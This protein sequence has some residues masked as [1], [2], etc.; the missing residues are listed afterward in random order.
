MSSPPPSSLSP[1]HEPPRVL[2][3]QECSHDTHCMSHRGDLY[4]ALITGGSRLVLLKNGVVLAQSCPL[5]DEAPTAAGAEMATSTAPTTAEAAATTASRGAT[6]CT[7]GEPA[8][9]LSAS[10][11]RVCAVSVHHFTDDVLRVAVATTAD[12]FLFEFDG[13]GQLWRDTRASSFWRTAE[14]TDAVHASWIPPPSSAAAS[15]GKAG[16]SAS[17]CTSMQGRS[18]VFQTSNASSSSAAAWGSGPITSGGQPTQRQ[19]GFTGGLRWRRVAFRLDGTLLATRPGLTEDGNTSLSSTTPNRGTT[20][21]PA[22]VRLR[23]ASAAAPATAVPVRISTPA[24]PSVVR[25]VDFVSVDTLCIVLDTEAVLVV[26]GNSNDAP[27]LTSVV[28][29][30]AAAVEL[31]D[32]VVWRSMGAYRSLAVCRVNHHVALAL[33]HATMVVFPSCVFPADSQVPMSSPASPGLVGERCFSSVASTTTP[34]L[35]STN[36]ASGGAHVTATVESR[37][38]AVAPTPAFLPTSHPTLVRGF[39][40]TPGQ[41]TGTPGASASPAAGGYTTLAERALTT[42]VGIY[43]ITDMQWHCVSSHTLLCVTCTRPQ[44]ETG[45]MMLYTVQSLSNVRR[46]TNVMRENAD[47]GWGPCRGGYEDEELD[48]ADAGLGLCGRSVKNIVQLVPAGVIVLA[49]TPSL[50]MPGLHAHPCAS[51]SPAFLVGNATSPASTAATPLHTSSLQL[52]TPDVA[53]LS[54]STVAGTTWGGAPPPPIAEM[55]TSLVPNFSHF[56]EANSLSSRMEFVHV[57][58]DGTV[59]TSSYAFGRQKHASFAKQRAVGLACRELLQPLLLLYSS[60]VKVTVLPTWRTRPIELGHDTSKQPCAVELMLGGARRYRM[61]LRFTSGVVLA[62]MVDLSAAVYRVECFLALGCAP[63]LSLR[64]V[65]PLAEAEKVHRQPAPSFVWSPAG[66]STILIAGLLGFPTPALPIPSETPLSLPKAPESFL[67]G[68][69]EGAEDSEAAQ[70]AGGSTSAD[71]PVVTRTVSATSSRNATHAASDSAE[72]VMPPRTVWAVVLLQV[73]PSGMQARVLTVAP[74]TEVHIPGVSLTGAHDG[75]GSGSD[76][77]DARQQASA[78]AAA[79]AASTSAR[80]VPPMPLTTASTAAAAGCAAQVTEDD[81]VSFMTLRC[82]EKLRFM[83]ALLKAAQQDAGRLLAQLIAKYGA[84]EESGEAVGVTQASEKGARMDDGEVEAVP[85]MSRP[86]PVLRSLSVLTSGCIGPGGEVLLLVRANAL[87]GG[88]REGGEGGGAAGLIR[89]RPPCLEALA[90]VHHL[91][92]AGGC[93]IPFEPIVAEYVPVLAEVQQRWWSKPLRPAQLSSTCGDTSPRRLEGWVQDVREALCACQRVSAAAEGAAVVQCQVVPGSP[94]TTYVRVRTPLSPDTGEVGAPTSLQRLLLPSTIDPRSITCVTGALLVNNDVVIGVL[95]RTSEV[96]SGA[97]SV[98][99]LYGCPATQSLAAS[100]KATAAATA[101]PSDNTGVAAACLASGSSEFGLEATLPGVDAFYLSASGEAVVLRRWPVQVGMGP[102]PPTESAAVHGSRFERWLRC[103]PKGSDSGYSYVQDCA[104][105]PPCG[106]TGGLPGIGGRGS[107][108]AP[109]TVTALMTLDVTGAWGASPVGLSVADAAKLGS[110]RTSTCHIL[111]ATTSN[112][113]IH[114][115]QLPLRSSGATASASGSSSASV[116]GEAALP[117]YHPDAVMQLIGMGR[118]NALGKVLTCVAD[119]VREVVAPVE[120]DG[121]ASTVDESSSMMLFDQSPEELARRL[122]SSAVARD[123]HDRPKVTQYEEVLRRVTPPQ[124]SV[125]ALLAEEMQANATAPGPSSLAPSTT[126]GVRFYDF[127]ATCGALVS[128]LTQLLPQVTLGRLDN[129]EHLKLLCILEALRDTL[130][131]SRSV[132]EAAARYLFYSR[133]VG[134]GRRL[135]L[136]SADTPAAAATDSCAPINSVLHFE[137]ARTATRIV[138]T[139]SY[140]WAAMS[141]SQS[142]LLSLLFDRASTVYVDGGAGGGAAVGGGGTGEALAPVTGGASAQDLT[143][144]QVK[145]SGVAFWL[146]SAAD[147]RT[148][149]DRVA[150]HQ[151]QSTKELTDCALM[152]CTARKVGTLAALAKAQNNQRLHAFFSRDFSKDEHNRA[153]AAANAYAAISKNMPQYGAAFFLLAGDVRSAVQVLLQRC[154]NPSLALFVLRAAGD[155]LEE[156]PSGA[157]T[158]LEWYIAQR[159]AEAEVCGALDM[160]ELACLSWID[161]NPPRVSP[162]VA[163]QRRIRALQRIAAHPTAHPEALCA[164]RYARDCVA[165]LAYRGDQF[166]SPAREVVFL[167]RLG[168]YCL[169]HR[170]G[171]NGYLHYHDAEALLRGL[172]AETAA[173]ARSGTLQRTSNGGG[174]S[175]RAPPQTAKMAADFNTGTLLFRGFGGSDD[176]D[177]GGSDDGGAPAHA[178]Q[179]SSSSAVGVSAADASSPLFTLSDAAAAAVEAEVQYVYARTGATGRPG[180][181]AA[182]SASVT[183]DAGECKDILRRMLLSFTTASSFMPMSNMAAADGGGG[184]AESGLMPSLATSSSSARANPHALFQQLLTSLLHL[185]SAGEANAQPEVPSLSITPRKP[186]DGGWC[187]LC[188]PLLHFLLSN[189]ALE[190]ANY[191][192]LLA[193]QRIPVSTEGVLKA[194]VQAKLLSDDGDEVQGAS[195]TPPPDADA[196]TTAPPLTASPSPLH[197]PLT[198]FFHLLV[199]HMRRH[200]RDAWAADG[201]R[202]GGGQASTSPGRQLEP[203]GGKGWVWGVGNDDDAEAVAE[204]DDTMRGSSE[205]DDQVHRSMFDALLAAGVAEEESSDRGARV[206][207]PSC[208]AGA[209]WRSFSPRA[210]ADGATIDGDAPGDSMP[211]RLTDSAQVSLLLSCCQAQLH[212]RLMAHLK[213]LTQAELD[214]EVITPTTQRAMDAGI[215]YADALSPEAQAAVVQRRLLQCTLL[216]DV[217]SRWSTL[218]EECMMRIYAAQPQ[219]APGPLT[220]PNGVFLEVQQMVSLMRAVLV[221]VLDA[222]PRYMQASASQGTAEASAAAECGCAKKEA[223]DGASDPVTPPPPGKSTTSWL[224]DNTL[225]LLELCATQLEL[226]WTLPAPAL[227]QCSQLAAP[228]RAAVELLQESTASHTSARAL[229]EGMLRPVKVA[230]DPLADHNRLSNAGTRFNDAASASQ[231]LFAFSGSATP[232]SSSHRTRTASPSAPDVTPSPDE[233]QQCNGHTDVYCPAL[234]YMQLAWMRRHH[235]HALLRGLLLMVTLNRGQGQGQRP[236]STDRL[237]LAQ[238]NHSATGVHFD[239]SSCD[240]VVW[241]TES[242]TSVG[243]GFRELLAGDNEEALWKQATERNL[244]TA[245]F[246]LG[247]TAQHERLRLAMEHAEQQYTPAVIAAVAA[248]SALESRPRLG[249][250]ANAMP[251]S[252]PHLPFFVSRHL[253]GHL[254]L[255]PFASQE[256]VASFRCA[257]RHGQSAMGSCSGTNGGVGTSSSNAYGWRAWGV[258]AGPTA[259][260]PAHSARLAC[261]GGGAAVSSWLDRDGRYAVTPVAF[262]PNGYIIAVGLSDGSVAGWRCAAAAVESPPAFFVPQL[263]APFGIRSCTFCGDRS[264]LVVVVGV[265]KESHQ[266]RCGYATA[267]SAPSLGISADAPLSG[268]A[269]P[270]VASSVAATLDSASATWPTTPASFD[271]GEMVGEMLILD[272]MLGAGTITARCALPFIPS[273][274][275]YITSLRAV[276][277]VSVDGMLATYAVA[278]GRLA[279]L[280]T[281]P[282]TTVL[283]SA[284]GPSLGADGGDAGAGVASSRSGASESDT[285]YITCVARSSYDPLVAFGVSNGLVLLLHFRSISAAMARTERRIRDEGEDTFVYYPP[286]VFSAGFDATGSRRSKRGAAQHTKSC[287]VASMS[288]RARV[289]SEVAAPAMGREF[290]AR[291]PEKTVLSEATCMQVAPHI[292]TRSAIVDLVFSPSMLLAG[293]EDGKVMAASLIAHATRARLTAG[294]TIPSDLLEWL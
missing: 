265:A 114:V 291:L 116:L 186:A 47:G 246:T 84:M 23:G 37:D 149:A 261:S 210:D 9:A 28:G 17:R 212:L 100:R 230:A 280:G 290:L 61:V 182:T 35:F 187:A 41:P 167:L 206:C 161:V 110:S 198:A 78:Q 205:D 87:C 77:Q 284:L 247:L 80:D 93:Y 228:T 223:H 85:V 170:L 57:E 108:V 148:M 164:L 168:R 213:Q 271:A 292:N 32:R 25:A 53:A 195:A 54:V 279:V 193:L 30:A 255:Y 285:V 224:E 209:S 82:P 156:Q 240:S 286:P 4:T 249:E 220:D 288:V 21:T 136:T 123:F 239:A 45:Y 7:R 1:P 50:R 233:P 65:V 122:C 196:A 10:A 117:Q 229:L 86:H 2:F 49:Y 281:V 52:E 81:V 216:L 143:W 235:T 104:W 88:S 115:R 248:K 16:C 278:T 112:S 153:A 18:N 241:T 262:S 242:G 176:D 277:M 179:G 250:A 97:S 44:E 90:P 133:Y 194:A 102:P 19:C 94:G 34:S 120:A 231:R 29:S 96:S 141:D 160:W 91:V 145:Q 287:A 131:L 189:V 8:R 169:A 11:S 178:R 190:C 275:V 215:L 42:S 192:V 274:G 276:L 70:R 109:E 201:G 74:L 177:E 155:A 40:G 166:L 59:R 244:A 142:T 222:P 98:L 5:F 31:P 63:L 130:P 159:T 171:L 269:S 140:M 258:A 199:H 294:C 67:E 36:P 238:H 73:E 158:A 282:V 175:R 75:G 22:G 256:C 226:F 24:H 185:L 111:Y 137:V 283:R 259:A 267:D 55:H 33:G 183:A 103:F 62:V 95:C 15:S 273:Y 152:Y 207:R 3:P 172:R 20:L 263:F 128:E 64:T 208:S 236:V 72:T 138:T 129:H 101:K 127:S 225:T 89:L 165:A 252:H 218:S 203:G 150:R 200:Y 26:L 99:Y 227:A 243:H 134:L 234:S 157:E 58:G 219:Y 180:S 260:V 119:A 66:S 253:D 266:Y 13:A 204:E 257:G 132:D 146:H 173:A 12:V 38:F 6:A 76:A 135:Q 191:I 202:L 83:P 113:F 254:D 181:D 106:V 151:Y 126:A 124:L 188:V 48:I 211:L 163:V 147:L 118:W 289:T 71:L 56:A 293:L 251:S 162:E 221:A 68:E 69:K 125:A 107:A 245:A 60:L 39:A 232:A 139:A 144:E 46:Y 14:D 197:R 174:T 51:G 92:A 121:A 43:H 237:I 27:A 79:S 272:I 105:C 217:T 268:L 214:S 184:G 270:L 264:S 154:H